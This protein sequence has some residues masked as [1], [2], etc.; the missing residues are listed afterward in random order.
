MERER[1]REREREGVC[2]CM[3]VYVCVCVCWVRESSVQLKS[4][5]LRTIALPARAGVRS[6]VLLYQ[7]L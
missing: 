1:E 6:G 4:R 5:T 3:C 2:V 7:V